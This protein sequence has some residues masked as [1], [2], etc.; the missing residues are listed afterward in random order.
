M[1][2]TARTI[3]VQWPIMYE[4]PGCQNYVLIN[5]SKLP[6]KQS[7]HQRRTHTLAKKTYVQVTLGALP[8]SAPIHLPACSFEVPQTIKHLTHVVQKT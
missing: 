7:Q 8:E 4:T 2:D 5:L 3:S 6:S 1:Q